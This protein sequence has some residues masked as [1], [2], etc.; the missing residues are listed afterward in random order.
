[1]DE[2]KL[3]ESFSELDEEILERSEGKKKTGLWL[4]WAAAAVLLIAAAATAVVLLL[5]PRE[6][7]N[8]VSI[9]G[10]SREY[11]NATASSEEL[12]VIWP[13]EYQT[14]PERYSAMEFSDRQYGIKRTE[15]LK[16][17][18]VLG[19]LAGTCTAFGADTYTETQYQKEFAVWS[20]C[21][22]DVNSMA[23][24][25]MDGEFYV[26]QNLEYAPPQT[27]GK[28][29]DMYSLEKNLKLSSFE[30][31]VEGEESWYLL[32]E[33]EKIWQILKSC[34][35]APFIEDDPWSESR[36]NQISFTVTSEVLGVYKNSFAITKD[37]YVKTNVFNWG[38]TFYIGQ[39]KAEEI[40]AYVQAHSQTTEPESYAYRLAGTIIDVNEDYM[41]IDD[42]LMCLHPEDGMIFRISMEDIRIRR[43]TEFGGIAEGDFVVVWFTDP[44][45]PN[46][47]NLLSGV[48]SIA[49]AVYYEGNVLIPE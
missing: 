39:E 8:L 16:D 17:L 29:L 18:T 10:I 34:T 14:E 47:Q 23:A 11:K 37:G 48:Y 36:K 30:M 12:A 15:P 25:Q 2:M 26:F 46:G 1:M 28:L 20:V 3:Y 40:Y 44:I 31:T 19:E 5:P 13:W 9:G 33:D 32:E 4:A 45:D 6:T 21:G 24:V 27:L 35:D 49:S 42:S 43:Y 7:G 38:Y 22:I 41:L